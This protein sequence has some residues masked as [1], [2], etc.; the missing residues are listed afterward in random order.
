MDN[1]SMTMECV[2]LRSGKHG[3]QDGSGAASFNSP[4]CVQYII[5]S[6]A[7][8]ACESKSLGLEAAPHDSERRGLRL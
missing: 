7:N 8:I 4:A 5:T 6:H 2:L 3:S 1:L